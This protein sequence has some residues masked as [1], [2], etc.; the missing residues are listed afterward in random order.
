MSLRTRELLG[1]CLNLFNFIFISPYLQ[2]HVLYLLA[3]FG[4]VVFVHVSL[5]HQKSILHISLC[6][7]PAVLSL[8]M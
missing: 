8:S 7:L 6:L 4:G 3:F 1:T 5:W 2:N